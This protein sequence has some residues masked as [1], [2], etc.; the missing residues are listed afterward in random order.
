MAVDHSAVQPQ[1]GTTSAIKVATLDATPANST[2]ITPP[3][4]A[5]RVTVRF[6]TSADAN[7]DG[8]FAF[9]GTDGAA[10]DADHFPI[11]SG[12][13]F[14]I[15]TALVGRNLDASP[16]FYLTATGVSSVAHIVYE[17]ESRGT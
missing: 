12:E 13:A 1:G 8:H 17:R 14:S 6:K 2:E 3:P 16:T 5:A 10:I 7:D 9:E 4:W 11:A 15:S